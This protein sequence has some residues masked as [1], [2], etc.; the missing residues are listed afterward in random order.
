MAAVSTSTRTKRFLFDR[1]FD[2]PS[3]VYLPGEKYG[4]KIEV[5]LPKS[6]DKDQGK[7]ADAADDAPPPPPAKMYTQEQLDAARE[8]GHVE[9]HTAA[10][11]DA[12]TA[13]EHYVADAISLI[14][15]GLEVLDDKQADANREI[16][17]LAMRMVYAVVEKVI[18]AH[19][20]A[21]AV[22]SVEAL[23]RDILPLVYDEPTL[24]VRTHVMIAEDVQEKMTEI[25][26]KSNFRGSV[27]VV[28][29]YELQPGDCRVE[30]DGGGADRD[31]G[32][33]WH[34]IRVIIGEDIGRVD[35]D[36]L[37]TA[38]NEAEDK[39]EENVAEPDQPVDDVESDQEEGL[40]PSDS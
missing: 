30:W 2:D 5:A 22:E 15:K 10:L 27:E 19:G 26:R 11:E 29:D 9:G 38:A 40:E 17:E 4:P 8:E 31:E 18:P 6:K 32:R 34:D 35:L 33:L 23:V 21:H 13:R 28:P 7:A 36:E 20:K 39:A 12:E 25:C 24:I 14:A 16:G 3:K 1:S 37:E